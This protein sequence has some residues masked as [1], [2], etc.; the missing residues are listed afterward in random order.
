MDVVRV[1]TFKKCHLLVMKN[2]KVEMERVDTL[3]K[4]LVPQVV[5]VQLDV[6]NLPIFPLNY[7]WSGSMV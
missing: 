2:G 7:L 1:V 5:K 4:T 3:S 6:S